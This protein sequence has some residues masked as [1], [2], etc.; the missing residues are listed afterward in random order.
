MLISGLAAKEDFVIKPVTLTKKIHKPS[1]H[2]TEKI[3]LGEA[4]ALFHIMQSTL[5]FIQNDNSTKNSLHIKP[6][7]SSEAILEEKI[8]ER[9]NYAISV[10]EKSGY[11]LGQY[12]VVD[13]AAWIEVINMA[14]SKLRLGDSSFNVAKAI[15]PYF[16]LRSVHYLRE[17]NGDPDIAR[18]IVE[19]QAIKLKS[20][21]T[22]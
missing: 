6:F 11:Q 19:Q 21:L 15:L 13:S 22:F 4:T 3:F 2:K 7:L 16:L 8:I 5:E 1:F 18:N 10:L 17:C 20:S 14:L 12:V 9:E